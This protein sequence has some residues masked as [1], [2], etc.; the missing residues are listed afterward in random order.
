MAD[1]NV[2][3][4][5]GDLEI[6]K[7]SLEEN[8]PAI[9]TN[10]YMTRAEGSGFTVYPGSF[11]HARYMDAWKAAGR[12]KEFTSSSCDV[13][14]P[15]RAEVDGSRVLFIENRGY[16]PLPWAVEMF[17][18]RQKERYVIGTQGTGK[19][20]NVGLLAMYMCAVHPNFNF[21]NVAPTQY[22]SR[23]MLNTLIDN[24]SETP[25]LKKFIR[26]H[27]RKWYKEQPFITIDFLNGSRAEF[28]NVEKQAANIQ[29]TYGDWY[30]LDEA[31]LLNQLDETG[32]EILTGIFTGIAT[33]MRATRP[34]GTPRLGWLTM[35]SAAYDCDA[36]WD[37]FEAALKPN[38]YAWAK[39][40]L[41]K[42]NHY[43]T[44]ENMETF[45]RHAKL[46]GEEDQI[47][48]GL[49]P[50]PKG[51]EIAAHLVHAMFLPD[52]IPFAAAKVEEGVEG[53]KLESGLA[54]VQHYERPRER[55]HIYMMVGDPGTG[56]APDRNSPVVMV[57]DVTEFPEK[58]ADLSAFWWGDGGGRYTPFVSKFEE[59]ADKYKVGEQFR[60]Y[61]S[62]S[63]Q[64]AIAE[65][66]FE[67][68]G[69]SVIPLGFD[70]VKKWQ[71]LNALKLI[72][73][74]GLLSAPE[75][76]GLRQQLTRYR[77]PDAKIAQDLVSACSMGAFLLYPLYRMAYP[78][79][80]DS[81][82]AAAVKPVADLGR[83]YRPVFNRNH[84]SRWKA[85][86]Q[87]QR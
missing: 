25:F 84:R 40:V 41:H 71:Y 5:A 53:W 55:D 15:V 56:A 87:P 72:L 2:A 46:S 50:Q 8:N 52:A 9:F 33:R 18:A 35:T 66:S 13:L 37:R 51:A 21:Y 27:G 36:M 6:I 42:E 59:W 80:V 23:Q 61:D 44:E 47:M 38:K 63:N 4:N 65:L 60:G 31:G 22:Q 86:L 75:I 78:E 73:G 69:L 45:R 74:K 34:D 70:G 10:Y 32:A 12:P 30:H 48:N 39:L 49:R 20:A 76:H 82:E 7:H 24:I 58:P 16:I 14:F 3:L 1:N 17:R 43:L 67:A 19:T 77:I 26:F 83:D 79:D 68:G 64:K 54:G 11:K 85:E 57:W 28:L 29:S 62:T 81:R